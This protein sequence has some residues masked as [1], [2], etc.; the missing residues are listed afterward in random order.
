MPPLYLGDTP[1]TV[2]KGDTQ[3]NTVAIGETIMQVYATT[4][5]T[6]TTTTQAP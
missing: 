2:Y 3:I 1:V 6:T 5:T 4:T